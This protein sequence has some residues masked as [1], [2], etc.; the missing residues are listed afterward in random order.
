MEA[1]LHACS[2]VSAQVVPVPVGDRDN[3]VRYGVTLRCRWARVMHSIWV[4]IPKRELPLVLLLVFMVTVTALIVC[5][6]ANLKAT[7]QAPS[8]S[9]SLAFGPLT[10]AAPS[11]PGLH[12][13]TLAA[14]PE[15]PEARGPDSGG[16]GGML[17]VEPRLDRDPLSTGRHD[18]ESA[19]S[20]AGS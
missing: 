11:P 7:W 5:T 3:Q 2:L 4:R 8:L 12:V 18:S 6:T 15:I 13:R 1:Y 10:L 14:D 20:W 9:P 19:R 16:A 17:R